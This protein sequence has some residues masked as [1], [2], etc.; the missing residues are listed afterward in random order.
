LAEIDTAPVA[1]LP[2]ARGAEPAGSRQWDDFANVQDAARYASTWLAMMCARITGATAGLMQLR[3]EGEVLSVTWPELQTNLDDLAALASRALA[4]RRMAISLGRAGPHDKTPQPVGLLVAVPLGVSKEPVGVVVVALSTTRGATSLAPETV[5]EQIRWGAGWIEVLPWARKSVEESRYRLRA[6]TCLDLLAAIGDNVGLKSTA[7]AVVNELGSDMKCDRVSLGVTGQNG[8]IRIRAISQSTNPR[9]SGLIVDAIENAMEEA[10]DQRASVSYPALPASERAI[11]VA[12]RTLLKN[13]GLRSSSVLTVV[14]SAERDQPFG[15]ITFERHN[16]EPFSDEFRILAETIASFLGSSLAL[17]HK[18]DRLIGGRIV[19]FVSE[20]I[21]LITG[22]RRPALK[23]ATAALAAAL[24]FLVVADGTHRVTGKA[25]VEGEIQRAVVSPFDGY[26]RQAPARAGDVVKKGDV[27]AALD[28]RDLVLE[29]LNWRAEREKLQQKERDALAR[30]DRSNVM[31]LRAQVDQAT[32]Q[33][34]LAEDK[35]SRSKFVAP[36]D[37]VIVSGDLSQMLGSPVEKGKV[38]FEIA[39]LDS[40]RLIVQVDERDIRYAAT[41]Q[42]GAVAL[43][44]RPIDQL[45]FALTKIM[46]V[47]VADEGKNTFRVEA[48]IDA[49]DMSM[50]PGMEGIAKI[51]IGQRSLLWIWTHA[52]TEWIHLT[53]WKYLP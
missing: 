42:K 16:D 40:Y 32:A 24:I 15:A 28:D 44:G 22:P 26:I 35:L 20:K 43:A 11:S 14:L 52:I 36:F 49:G 50:R 17:Q 5:A 27:L 37:G 9:Q 47:T 8:A 2:M 46:P 18:N 25:V 6:T 39:P 51:D 53:I 41:G 38:L 19:D 1:A 12:H 33:L 21:S 23:L 30:H 34:N 48:A 3:L 29:R 45:P 7:M 31:V 4:E 13:V 10:C